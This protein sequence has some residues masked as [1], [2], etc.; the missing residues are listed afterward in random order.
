MSGDERRTVQALLA[1]AGLTVPS[2]EL[3]TLVV[4]YPNLRRSLD[5]LFEV[6]VDD[7]AE[8]GPSVFS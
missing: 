3:E 7:E 6:E 4:S 8:P 5:A 2:D 1:A